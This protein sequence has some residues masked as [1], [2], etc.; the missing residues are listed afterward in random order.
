MFVWWWDRLCRF[1]PFFIIRLSSSFRVY[2]SSSPPASVSVDPPPPP[3]RD[4]WGVVYDILRLVRFLFGFPNFIQHL[5]IAPCSAIEVTET[6]SK[7]DKWH[8]HTHTPPPPQPMDQIR[9]FDFLNNKFLIPFL[10]TVN[11][12]IQPFPHFQL[13]Y[14]YCIIFYFFICF[15]PLNK[16]AVLVTCRSEFRLVRNLIV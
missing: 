3:L 8:T 1:H 7:P 15:L 12:N 10:I 2:S 11:I 5:G 16:T 14:I 6:I 4:A 9:H 13:L